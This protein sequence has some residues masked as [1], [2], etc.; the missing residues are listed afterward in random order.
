MFVEQGQLAGHPQLD[1]F[2]T[3]GSSEQEGTVRT[4][5]PLVS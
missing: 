3:S 5:A 1:E 2:S 4:L